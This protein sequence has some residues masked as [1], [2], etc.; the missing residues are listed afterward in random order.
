MSGIVVDGNNQIKLIHSKWLILSRWLGDKQKPTKLEFEQEISETVEHS[1]ALELMEE[2]G[3]FQRSDVMWPLQCCRW[4]DASLTPWKAWKQARTAQFSQ[5]TANA[6]STRASG[7][8]APGFRLNIQLPR[9]HP[10][11]SMQDAATR[12]F[13]GIKGEFCSAFCSVF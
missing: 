2:Q 10:M 9:V 1:L 4:Q 13:A 12:F 7:S 5:E 3:H 11:D 6:G 8:K